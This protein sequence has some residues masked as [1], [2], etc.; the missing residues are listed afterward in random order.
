L[1]VNFSIHLVPDTAD[2]R[3]AVA[4]E[5]GDLL[6]RVGEPGDGA[7][8]GKILLSAIRTAI[9]V[10][11]D[12]TDYTVTVPAADVVPGIGQL[13]SVGTITFV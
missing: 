2:T 9:G 12:V 8:R 5:L 10:A 6:G 1:A 13:P 4:A 11:T 7:G 3:A